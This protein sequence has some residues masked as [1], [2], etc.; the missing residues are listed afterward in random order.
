MARETR[1]DA[2]DDGMKTDHHME[3]TVIP[4][5]S[6]RGY[7]DSKS[8][9]QIRADTVGADVDVQ[10]PMAQN[11]VEVLEDG[12][13]RTVHLTQA[14]VKKLVDANRVRG[15]DVFSDHPPMAISY[16]QIMPPRPL[17]GT[18][19][20]ADP[21]QPVQAEQPSVIPEIRAAP[22]VVPPDVAA[23]AAASAPTMPAPNAGYT[24]P[25]PRKKVQFSGEFGSLAY[26]Y[27]D[28]HVHGIYFIMV[29]HSRARE[30]FE[31]P[32]GDKPVR[33]SFGAVKYACYPGPQFPLFPNGDL[34]VTVYLIDEEATLR[35]NG[36]GG[37]DGK[38]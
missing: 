23:Y 35:L 17:P 33:I 29:Q 6:S 13:V 14:D 38:A 21:L 5:A 32:S 1:Y 19:Q 31:A 9:P 18:V 36:Q 25:K 10:Q 16:D 8:L 34:F 20:L 4:K 11:L 26:H 24:Q 28:V 37:A 12:S 27:E 2:Y 7:W 22:P 3:G 30:F 15:K